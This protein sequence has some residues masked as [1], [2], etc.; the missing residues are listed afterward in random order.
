MVMKFRTFWY[1][2]LWNPSSNKVVIAFLR[3]CAISRYRDIARYHNILEVCCGEGFWLPTYQISA[4]SVHWL[5]H[6]EGKC[7]FQD[8]RQCSAILNRISLKINRLGDLVLEISH[9][10]NCVDKLIRFW[11]ILRIHRQTYIHTYIQ[12]DRRTTA[13]LSS[14]ATRAIIN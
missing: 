12:T 11:D 8:G 7:V 4:K 3:C 10:K 13:K 5:G 1:I 6:N 9:T 14:P 2:T